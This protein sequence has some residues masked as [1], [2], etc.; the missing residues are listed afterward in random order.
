MRTKISAD[1]RWFRHVTDGSIGMVAWYRGD[2]ADA[3]A[4]LEEATGSLGRF[5]P[6]RLRIGV[7]CSQ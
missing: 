2:F 1:D 5:E 4:M 7:V 3:R 6:H